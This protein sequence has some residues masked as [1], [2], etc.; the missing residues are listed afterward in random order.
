M[1]SRFFE[2]PTLNS[3]Y[4]YPS[5]HW[6]LDAA[7]QPTQ[8]INKAHPGAE[9]ITTISKPRKRKGSTEQSSLLFDEG[10]GFSIEKQAYDHTA[11]VNGT[12]Q[13]V[14]R[15]CRLPNPSQWRVTE[16]T[17][18]LLQDWCHYKFSGVRP[19]LCQVEVAETAIWFTEV[20]PHWV[21]GINNHGNYGRWAFAEFAYIR[22][23][24][25]DLKAKVKDIATR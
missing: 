24:Q 9:F 20:A 22:G 11:I 5:W 23:R 12:R 25:P 18:R 8:K 17:T 16:E 7:G 1:D 6:G 15:W 3:P 10:R 2:L 19:L 21:P 14:D 13:E 4:E